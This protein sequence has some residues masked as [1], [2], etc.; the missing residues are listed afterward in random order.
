[1]AKRVAIGIDLGTTH[2]CVGAFT[3]GRVEI[4]HNKLGHRITPSYVAF[5]EEE[6]LVGEAAKIQQ[7]TNHENTIYE[8]KRIIGLRFDDKIVQDE[9]E[10]WPFKLVYDKGSP[11]VDVTYKFESKT[12]SP[13][14]ISGFVLR[15]MKQIAEEYLGQKVTDAVITVPAYFNDSQRQATKDA[16]EIAGLNV[17][18]ILNEPTAAALAYGLEKKISNLQNLLVYDLGGGTFD[19]VIL[20]ILNGNYDVK[21]VAGDPHLGGGDFDNILVQNFVEEI[22]KK[23][24]KDISNNRKAM[25]RL[26]RACEEAK[27]TL[28]AFLNAKIDIACLFDGED[29]HSSIS[30]NKFNHLCSDLFNQTLNLVTSALNDARVDPSEVSEVIIVGGSTRIPKI[31]SL[32]E[33]FFVGK[34]LNKS[35]NADEAVAYGAAYRA[36]LSSGECSVREAILSDVCPLSLGTDEPDGT[37]TVAIQRNTKIPTTVTLERT[38]IYDNQTNMKFSI[39]EGERTR[40]EQ[41][42]LLGTFKLSN[43]EQAREGVP[44]VNLTFTIDEDGILHCR[45]IDSKTGHEN[46][47]T[48]TSNKGRLNRTEIERMVVEYNE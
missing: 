1:M 42:H 39:Y 44:T 20:S 37:V 32:L 31:Q 4:I 41:N 2:S 6:R 11:K 47:I 5:T 24:G 48:I 9:K 18:S 26:R 45:A 27:C 40:R 36:A 13:E 19:V 25:T 22:K 10:T 30:R 17:L 23:Y 28:S 46:G 35:I 34:K 15:Y 38:T 8:I 7:F 21:S 14:E 33:E 16:G 12:F 29:F 3:N 43:I